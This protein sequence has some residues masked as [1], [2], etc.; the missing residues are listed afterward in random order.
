MRLAR[1]SLHPIYFQK[2]FQFDLKLEKF[3]SFAI[4]PDF[5]LNVRTFQIFHLRF[6]KI[7]E[8]FFKAR[9]DTFRRPF[10]ICPR[11]L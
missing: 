11:L 7:L 10:Q 1:S 9:Y 3:V 2:I 5:D 4:R 6:I 8:D